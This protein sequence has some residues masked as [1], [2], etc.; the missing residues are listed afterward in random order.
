MSNDPNDFVAAFF[1]KSGS[2]I[3][4]PMAKSMPSALSWQ[5]RF[6]ILSDSQ[7]MLYYFKVRV[8]GRGGEGRAREG[9][10]QRQ[11][12]QEGRRRGRGRGSR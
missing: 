8:M 5:R 3:D 1:D 2:N 9:G 6:F 7:K 4:S 12:Q 10:V 11:R